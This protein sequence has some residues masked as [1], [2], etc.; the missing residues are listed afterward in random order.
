MCDKEFS[1]KEERDSF[2]IAE[3]ISHLK[4]LGR[5]SYKIEEEPFDTEILTAIEMEDREPG[6][7][8]TSKISGN[9]NEESE[10]YDVETLTA[11]EK[12]DRVSGQNI[13]EKNGD[14]SREEE[15]FDIKIITEND[16]TESSGNCKPHDIEILTAS[17]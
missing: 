10:Q 14:Y 1:S 8:I 4:T 7:N 3:V 9:D 12:E 5:G 6:Q 11:S 16:V 13:T 17:D 15:P 2:E